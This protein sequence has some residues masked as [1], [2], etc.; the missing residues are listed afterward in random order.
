MAWQKLALR[1]A[2]EHTDSLSELLQAAGAIS[3]TLEDAAN[4]LLIE[5]HWHEMPL[6]RQVTLSA[7]FPKT[8]DTAM[9]LSAIEAAGIG[10]LATP[11]TSAI[12][13]QA[14]ERVWMDR[15][16]PI[17]VGRGLWICPSWREPVEPDAVNVILDPGL[18]FG[19]GT[20]ATTALCLEW[21][22]ELDLHGRQ[23]I[24]Y[25][26]GSG[27]L[28]VA[29]LKLGAARAWAT[30]LDPQALEVARENAARNQVVD[31][32][33]VCEPAQLPMGLQ[34]DVVVANILAAALVELAPML[35]ACTRNHG[36]I[37]LSGI[38]AHQADD[39]ADA[40]RDTFELARRN[41]EDWVLLTGRKR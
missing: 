30:D 14:W 35:I 28:A 18:A 34:G 23:V 12:A 11:E 39:V 13:D 32:L 33:S 25:G 31:R 29:A 6:W 26:C 38:M 27:I 15:Y 17:K 5:T 1:V 40:Y 19:T 8:A 21:L 22:A 3:L 16:H 20:H 10:L 7:L 4:E 9:V 37:A 2:Q 41:R 24:D 36:Q